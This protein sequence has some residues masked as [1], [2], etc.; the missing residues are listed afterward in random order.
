MK[1]P[2]KLRLKPVEVDAMQYTGRN[3]DALMAWIR[4]IY[5]DTY[6]VSFSVNRD[7][8]TVGYA[9]IDGASRIP[10]IEYVEVETG[11]STFRIY[12]N[13]WVFRS[14]EG[15]LSIHNHAEVQRK[16]ARII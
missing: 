6:G 7:Y 15:L 3:D 9:S 10:P 1:E 4:A 14:A 5:S 2:I 8:P 13:Q 16:Y 12:K 11:I